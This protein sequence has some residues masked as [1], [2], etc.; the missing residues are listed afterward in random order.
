MRKDKRKVRYV[1]MGEEEVINLSQQHI[2]SANRSHEARVA[3]R[4]DGRLIAVRNQS[5]PIAN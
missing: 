4:S 3:N 5:Q 1:F 2:A